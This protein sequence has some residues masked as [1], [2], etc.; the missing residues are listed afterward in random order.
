M[1]LTRH[2]QFL[3]ALPE[4][5]GPRALSYY[6][7]RRS[8]S[9]VYKTTATLASELEVIDQQ[10]DLIFKSR[11]IDDATGYALGLVASRV[12]LTRAD[13][14]TDAELRYRIRREIFIQESWGNIEQIKRL[15]SDIFWND[16][17]FENNKAKQ[18]FVTLNGWTELTPGRAENSWVYRGIGWP[19]DQKWVGLTEYKPEMPLYCSVFFPRSWLRLADRKFFKFSATGE[20]IYASP[21][22]FSAAPFI[23]LGPKGGLQ[24]LIDWVDRI[25]G[26]GIYV[27]LR[28][29]GGFR[30]SAD[31]AEHL[32]SPNGFSS[33]RFTGT[34]REMATNMSALAR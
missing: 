31:N 3:K 34:I 33:G 24:V 32:N 5:N 30:F 10:L 11:S 9:N 1:S 28:T 2:E 21:Y 18:V 13:G 26:A 29:Y 22:G 6:Y 17:L 15:V 12:G 27:E 20:E 14:E 19:A 8:T 7:D 16:L 25:R 23:S 4:P